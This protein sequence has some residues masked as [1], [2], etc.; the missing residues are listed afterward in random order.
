MNQKVITTL[1]ALLLV[2][3][4]GYA[5]GTMQATNNNN[6]PQVLP[7]ITVSPST[8]IIPST[9]LAGATSVKVYL[10]NNTLFNTTGSTIYWQPT[11][12]TTLRNDVA[13]FAIEEIILGPTETEKSQGFAPSIGPDRFVTFIDAS[14]CS[15]KDFTLNISQGS[16]ILRF[17]RATTLSG[18]MSG[19]IVSEQITETLKQFP[20]IQKVTILNKN[21][22]CFNDMK[23]SGECT[24]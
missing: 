10:F 6:P 14:N 24:K 13:T 2:G 9:T 17:C 16:A 15:G 22:T 23:G 18:D 1:A 8:S 3:A 19:F 12:R 4:T 5:L 21:G 11:L 20:E 7:T